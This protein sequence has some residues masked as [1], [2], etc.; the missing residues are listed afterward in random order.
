MD[1]KVLDVALKFQFEL[2]RERLD[3]AASVAKAAEACANAGNVKKAAKILL[4]VDQPI[5]EA[6]TLANA[7]SLL[8]RV[9]R[10]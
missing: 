6:Q 3:E 9:G 8:N 4:D 5:Y 1:T 10:S 2:I 7:V